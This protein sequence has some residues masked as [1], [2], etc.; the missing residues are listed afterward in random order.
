MFAAQ[1]CVYAANFV[2][3]ALSAQTA[4][5]EKHR[6]LVGTCSVNEKNEVS[7]LEYHEAV[8]QI[9]VAAVYNHPDQV[10]ALEPSPNALDLVLTSHESPGGDAAVS[11][12][13]MPHQTEESVQ[14]GTV[15]EDKLELQ[16][17]ATWVPPAH[18]SQSSSS[19][20]PVQSLRWHPTKTTAVLATDTGSVHLLTLAEASVSRAEAFAFDTSDGD[21]HVCSSLTR[22]V[23]AWDPHASANAAAAHGPTLHL[24]DTR[25][26]KAAHVLA[27]A[28]AG[29]IRDVEF[30]PNKPS[31]LVTCGDDRKVKFWDVRNLVTPVRT[32]AGHSHYAWCVRFNPFHDQL[33]LSGGSDNLVNLWR[34]A[35]CSSAPWISADDAAV[36]SS[37]TSSSSSS[38][39]GGGSSS[40]SGIGAAGGD[41]SGAGGD[42]N[43]SS[44]DPPDVK[45]RVIDQHEDSVYGVAWSPADAWMYCSLSYD[46]T[47]ILNH[48]PSSEKYKILL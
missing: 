46:G 35:S 48:V 1:S 39:G 2:A 28:H 8:N 16:Q 47:V 12:W 42:V 24:L 33:L 23:A 41:E 34:V 11:L 43:S 3:R 19:S 9:E 45:V 31:V 29:A 40:G 37:G 26:M 13:R 5:R 36:G 38:S 32:L 21:L 44:S 10:W 7:V 14:A 15:V 6:F 25:K 30:N 17:V 27:Q 22:G 20:S 18:T 4:S